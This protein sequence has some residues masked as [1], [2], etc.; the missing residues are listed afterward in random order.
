[1]LKASQCPL[2]EPV[3]LIER[4]SGTDRRKTPLSV[5]NPF[6]A[7]R[8]RELRRQ[9]D[10]SQL[11]LLD[12]YNPKILYLVTLILILS[13]IDALFTLLLMERGARELNPVMTFF[14]QYGPLV[15]M[16]AKHILTSMSVVIIVLLYHIRIQ[17]MKFQL[18]HLLYFFAGGFGITLIWE[19][20]LI[21]FHTL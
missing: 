18:G 14:L 3:V 15:F 9:S 21:K 1:M 2:D 4:R 6:C 8:R 11:K 12:H 16:T 7:A 5:F 19:L 17:R 13:M 10:R 20:T